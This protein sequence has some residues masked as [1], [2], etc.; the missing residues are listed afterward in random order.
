MKQ[1]EMENRALASIVNLID[2]LSL[3]ELMKHQECLTLFNANSTFR[4]TQKSKLLQKLAYQPLDVNSYMALV[5]MGMMWCLAS[6]TAEERVKSD[7][8]P[9]IWGDYTNKIGSVIL[10]CHVNATTI[11]CIND[12][13][14]YAESI[15]DDEHELHIQDQGPILNVYMKLADLFPTAC[16]FICSACNK[17]HLQALIKAQLS[18]LSK[19]ISHELVY[20]VDEDCVSLSPGDTKDSLSF[21]QV[22]ADTIMLSVYAALRSSCYSNPVV[23]DA[24]DTDMHIQAAAISHVIPDILC[25]KKKKQFFF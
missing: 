9:Y 12:P 7:G 6:P 17:K 10:A 3:P 25:I 19:S 4:K 8:S 15:K 22:E 5:D 21:N 20:S 1:G 2:V 11:I 24:E 13:Y 14:D 16:K 18:E 23:I